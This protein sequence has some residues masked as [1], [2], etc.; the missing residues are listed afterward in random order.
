MLQI[1][2]SCESQNVAAVVGVASRAVKAVQLF[3]NVATQS[4]VDNLYESTVEVKSGLRGDALQPRA[5][6]TAFKEAVLAACALKENTA[7]MVYGPR[8]VGKSTVVAAALQVVTMVFIGMFLTSVLLSCCVDNQLL[9]R[10]PVA[11]AH[12]RAVCS[13]WLM[14]AFCLHISTQYVVQSGFRCI[15][16]L[17]ALGGPCV[18]RDGTFDVM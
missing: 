12:A 3:D 17:L 14:L 10:Q 15:Y 1:M 2:L 6:F 13:M 4:A 9:R 18:L 5:C 11:C 7:L 16:Q 8:G